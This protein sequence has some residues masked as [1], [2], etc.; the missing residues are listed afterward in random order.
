MNATPKDSDAI[1]VQEYREAFQKIHATLTD[2]QLELLRWHFQ[3]PDRKTTARQMATEFGYS[4]YRSVN[5]Q[6]GGVGRFLCDLFGQVPGTVKLNR[7]L[8]I[9]RQKVDGKLEWFWQMREPA[10]QALQEL[11]WV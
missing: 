5:T 11:G 8:I 7:L 4:N 10:A 6:Y 2:R 9:T 1:T 3:R